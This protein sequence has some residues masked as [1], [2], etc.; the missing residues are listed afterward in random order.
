MGAPGL[1]VYQAAKA[2]VNTFSMSL[3][4]ELRSTG[5]SVTIVE[6][7]SLRTD[8]LTANSMT[9]LPISEAYVATL[10]PAAEWLRTQNGTQPADPVRAAEAVVRAAAM[11]EPPERLVL[12]SDALEYA[13]A[14]AQRLAESDARWTELSRSIDFPTAPASA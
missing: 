12:G 9:M 14:A 11:A 1:A 8:I 13:R 5:V 10:G 6:P 2:A 4:E 3:R 7:G